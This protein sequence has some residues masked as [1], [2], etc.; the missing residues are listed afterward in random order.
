MSA[1]ILVA[2]QKTS[3]EFFQPIGRTKG[4]AISGSSPPSLVEKATP[5]FGMPSMAKLMQ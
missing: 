2:E 4:S 1:D 5:N 3:G